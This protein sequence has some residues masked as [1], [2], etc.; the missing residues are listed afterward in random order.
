MHVQFNLNPLITHVRVWVALDRE[1]DWYISFTLC[2]GRTYLL[3]SL[4]KVQRTLQPT[5]CVLLKHNTTLPRCDCIGTLWDLYKDPLPW[6]NLL[7]F[8]T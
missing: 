3:T 1:H 8:Q 5:M 2:W 7:Q 6:E 4:I